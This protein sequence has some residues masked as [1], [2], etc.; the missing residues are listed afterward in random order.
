MAHAA[1]VVPARDSWVVDQAGV[2][3]ARTRLQLNQEL[4]RVQ[5]NGGPQL[6]V[7][8]L[9]RLDGEPVE[10]AALKIAEAYRLGQAGRDNG[11]LLLVALEDRELRIEVGQ[12]LEGDIPDAVASRIIRNTIVPEFRAGRF[13]HGIVL[14]V[15]EIL[16]RAGVELSAESAS[17]LPRGRPTPIRLSPALII[18]LVILWMLVSRLFRP[19]LFGWGHRRGG[20]G[21]WPRSGG[22]WGGGGWGG[23][24]GGWSGGGGGGFSGGGAS[25]RW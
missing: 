6:Q 1:F 13:E 8:V 12:G 25:G 14:G 22:G 10:S 18:F 4:E 24:G 15:T 9:P 7:V 23:G 5:Q 3:S 11:A 2:F 19:R 17:S 16:Q 20:F 21:Q